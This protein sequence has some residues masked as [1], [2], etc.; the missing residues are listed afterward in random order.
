VSQ[1]SYTGKV[2]IDTRCRPQKF[3]ISVPHT[4][5]Q[6][7]RASFEIRVVTDADFVDTIYWY[8]RLNWS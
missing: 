4:H 3:V 5:T 1:C 2:C 7:Y 6:L 8:V